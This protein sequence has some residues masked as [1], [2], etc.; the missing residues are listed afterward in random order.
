MISFNEEMIPFMSVSSASETSFPFKRAEKIQ[1]HLSKMIIPHDCL[2][3]KIKY[4][5]GVDVS[6]SDGRS[7][8]AVVVLEYATMN[9]IEQETSSQR[10]IFPYI[11]TFLAFRELPA[12]VAATRKLK[13]RPDIFMVDGHGT[14]HPRRFGFACHFGLAVKTPTIGVAKNLL[15]GEVK[16]SKGCWKPVIDGREVIGAAVFTKPSRKPIYV[17]V[18]HKVSLETAIRLVLDCAKIHRIP[19]PIRQAHIAAERAKQENSVHLNR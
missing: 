9:L 12:A 1:K 3:N 14:A 11:P 10:T 13:T 18:G 19:E 16:G 7:Y 15:C 8:G 2:P 5:A 17:S 6:Y 4:I